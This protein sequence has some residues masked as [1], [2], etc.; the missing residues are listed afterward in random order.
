MYWHEQHFVPIKAATEELKTLKDFFFPIKKFSSIHNF[1][2]TL[3]LLSW[4]KLGFESDLK[5]KSWSTSHMSGEKTQL[6]GVII[7]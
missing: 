1:G 2:K 6:H 3:H 7:E 5:R 4:L